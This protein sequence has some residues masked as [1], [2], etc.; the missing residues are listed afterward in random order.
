MFACPAG[1]LC[2]LTLRIVQL[3]EGGQLRPVLWKVADRVV[4]ARQHALP[5]MCVACLH[6]APVQHLVAF[7]DQRKRRGQRIVGQALRLQC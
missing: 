6:L 7:A 5:G 1:V 2:R 4:I 3:Q